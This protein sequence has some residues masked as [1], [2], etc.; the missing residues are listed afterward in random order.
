VRADDSITVGLARDERVA[1]IDDR[2]PGVVKV[3]VASGI[4]LRFRDFA[5][6]SA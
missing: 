5:I 3:T 4:A 2:E 6:V 1:S